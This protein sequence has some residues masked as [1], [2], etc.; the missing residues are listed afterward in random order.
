MNPNECKRTGSCPECERL[1]SELNHLQQEYYA[2]KR[3]IR[4]L[5]GDIEA[6]QNWIMELLNSYS[7]LKRQSSDTSGGLATDNTEADEIDVG[8]SVKSLVEEEKR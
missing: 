2:Q 5:K 1:A 8:D 6:K 7:D 4:Y 3:E